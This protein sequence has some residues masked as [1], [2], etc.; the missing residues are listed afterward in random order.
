V[1]PKRYSSRRQAFFDL[2]H[3]TQTTYWGTDQEARLPA[4]AGAGVA[5]P[6]LYLNSNIST[7][8][9]YQ[10]LP[11]SLSPYHKRSAYILADNVQRFCN[12]YGIENCGFLT[13]TFPDNVQEH[14]EASRRFNSMNSHFLSTFYGE[15]IWARERQKRGAW[16]YHI[17]I[18]CKGDIR[19]GF[20][21]AEY[22]AWLEDYKQGKKRRLRTGNNLLRNLWQL[23]NRAFPSY[24]FGRVELLPVRSSVD[25]VA[26][27]VG[28]YISKQI[29]QRPEDDKGVRLIGH[30]QGFVARS[31]KF[32]WNSQGAKDWRRKLSLFA[33]LSCCC[34]TFEEFSAAAGPKWAYRYKNMIMDYDN[35]MKARYK[36]EATFSWIQNALPAGNCR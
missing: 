11:N 34:D 2:I 9:S 35:H 25:A 16:H 36:E 1:K 33:R 14:K 30:S 4:S 22:R 23:N 5:D 6:V 28:K 18:Q 29:G 8:T 31:P 24:G 3:G 26:C 13:L 7:E 12:L 17:I 10:D 27:Y 15:W 19:T 32:S 21:W 20:D